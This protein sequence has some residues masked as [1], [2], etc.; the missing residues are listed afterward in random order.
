M[1]IALEERS[2]G[3]KTINHQQSGAIFDQHENVNLETIK[4][5]RQPTDK[6]Y[7]AET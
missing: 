4:P 6:V 3:V 7:Q 1:L 2:R 5:T